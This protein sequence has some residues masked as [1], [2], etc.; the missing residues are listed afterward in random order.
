MKWSS[1]IFKVP[2]GDEYIIYNTLN[3]GLIVINKDKYSSLSLSHDEMSHLVENE[4]IYPDDYDELSAYKSAF[5][6]DWDNSHFLKI[7]VLVTTRCNFRCPYCYQAGIDGNTLSESVMDTML[8]FL[9]KYI[10]QNSIDECDIEITGGEPTTNFDMVKLLLGRLDS[11]FQKYSVKYRTQIVTNGYLLTKEKIDYLLSYNLARIQLTL[12]GLRDVHDKRRILANGQGSFTKIMENVDYLLN[13]TDFPILNLR[14]N[15]DKSNAGD[16]AGLLM[17]LKER[18]GTEKIQ[19]SLGLI[20]KTVGGSEANSYISQFALENDDFIHNYL[21]LY[22]LAYDMG[23]EMED[24]FSFD[25]FCTAKLKH[26]FLIEP[27]GTLTKCVSGVGRGEFTVGNVKDGFDGTNYLL[28]EE[29]E[30]CLEKKCPFLPV[31]HAGCRFTS[32]VENGNL[33][34]V[35]CRKAM[36]E[37]VNGEILKLKYG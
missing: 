6:K 12:D 1:F 25:G 36:L 10:V 21:K 5:L 13:E 27:D 18:Y 17:Y 19:L 2:V 30:H 32:L 24:F 14:I 34:S 26:G 4:Y 15:Y 28:F 22:S 29:Y 33:S 31:C 11:I 20:T 9:E 8:V 7:H 16:I 37:K 23:F 35:Y 3:A